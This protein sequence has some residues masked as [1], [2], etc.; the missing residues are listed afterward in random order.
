MRIKFFLRIS[1]SKNLKTMKFDSFK[2]SGNNGNIFTNSKIYKNGEIIFANSKICEN[3]QHFQ[4][5]Q[6]YVKGEYIF[7]NSNIYGNWKCLEEFQN[8]WKR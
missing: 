3:W 2:K 5:A 4:D 8:L 6:I 7:T 1:V